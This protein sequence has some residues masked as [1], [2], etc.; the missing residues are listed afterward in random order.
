MK[1]SKIAA[2]CKEEKTAILYDQR[3]ED[4]GIEI[5]WLGNGRAVYPLFDAP[6]FDAASLVAAYDMTN[7]KQY[8]T[9]HQALPEALNFSDIDEDEKECV[10]IDTAIGVGGK[11]LRPYIT[12]RGVALLDEKLMAP[13]RDAD[14][15]QVRVYERYSKAGALYFAVKS[16][17]M[18]YAVILPTEVITGKLVDDLEV[19]WKLCKARRENMIDEEEAGDAASAED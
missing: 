7:K 4:G 2:L 12:E 19:L 13:L 6:L 10:P 17:F 3:T 9:H 15:G 11:I 16:G 1:I 5:Q 14:A 8:V 18:L